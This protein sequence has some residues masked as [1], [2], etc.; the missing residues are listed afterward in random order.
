[1]TT[2]ALTNHVQE[3][4]LA[5]IESPDPKSLE[6]VL[7]MGNLSSLTSSQRLQ[8]LAAVCRS[9]GLNPLTRP[10]EFMNIDGKLTI[11]AKKDCTEQLRQIHNVSIP[12]EFIS[13]NITE[14]VYVVTVTAFLPSGRSDTDVGAVSIMGLKGKDLSN[15]IMKGFTKAKRRVTL[16]ICGLGFMDES[17]VEDA[18]NTRHDQQQPSAVDKLKEFNRSK[19]ATQVVVEDVERP[20]NPEPEPAN[21]EL[22]KLLENMAKATDGDTLTMCREDMLALNL[23]DSELT[24]AKAALSAKRDELKLGWIKDEKRY[25]KV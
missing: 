23:E 14:G 3:D 19:S 12:K 2:S 5:F 1:M 6:Q 11:Y 15:A 25:D 7:A 20:N 13:T 24:T 4:A 22:M 21:A 18:Q 17:E 16:S 10:F 8:F 9:V